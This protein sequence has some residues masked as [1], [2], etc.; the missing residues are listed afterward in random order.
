[1]CF[2]FPNIDIFSFWLGFILASLSWWILSMLR[3]AFQHLRPMAQAKQAEKK[4]KIHASS[5]VEERYRQSVLLQA[6]G[7]L[8]RLWFWPLS[9]TL[10][11]SIDY[12]FENRIRSMGNPQRRSVCKSR[13]NRLGSSPSLES[14]GWA[15]R[16]TS[17]PP[18]CY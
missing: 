10:V 2:R 11:R 7:Q 15:Y 1:M 13:L 3:P 5:E 18:I 6:Q 4:E 9:G 16:L 17:R 12:L 8:F 14:R